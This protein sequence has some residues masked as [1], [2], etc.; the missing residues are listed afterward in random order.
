[1][2][3]EYAKFCW[4]C[5]KEKLYLPPLYND[6]VDCGGSV[7]CIGCGEIEVDNKGKR[8]DKL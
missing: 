4:D 6:F 3:Q 8:I 7:V 5:T 2:N 1:M